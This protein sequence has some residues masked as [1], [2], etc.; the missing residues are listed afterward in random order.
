MKLQALLRHALPNLREIPIGVFIDEVCVE[1]LDNVLSALK[2][3][4]SFCGLHIIS[5]A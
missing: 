1:Y 5:N 2:G 3:A 4:R